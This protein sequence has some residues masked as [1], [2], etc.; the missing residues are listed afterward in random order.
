[1]K[2]AVLHRYGAPEFGDFVDPDPGAY[3]DGVLVEVRS[4]TINSIDRVTAA[5]RH[6]LSPKTFPVVAGIEGA[7]V[8]ADNRRVYFGRPVIPFGSMA[9]S[10]VVSAGFVMPIPDSVAFPVAATLGNTGMAALMPLTDAARL[11]PGDNVVLLGG[12]GVVGRLAIQAARLLGAG[13]ITVVGRDEVALAATLPLGASATVSTE[14]LSVGRLTAAIREASGGVDVIVDYT[15]GEPALAALAAGNTGV[16][17]VQVGDRAGA[18]ATL[19]AQQLRSLGASVTGFMPV[20]HGPE[21]M[22]RAYQQLISW[23]DRADLTVD[24]ELIPLSDV[25]AAWERSGAVRHKLVLVP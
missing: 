5:G 11:K 25:T 22:T 4:A 3:P 17:L 20:H 6:Y 18:T 8:T 15:W 7:G 16:R 19:A 10:T 23:A 9:E 14:G 12:S 1:M 2:A 24:Y 21:A 13:T